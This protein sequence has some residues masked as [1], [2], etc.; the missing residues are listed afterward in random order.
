[1]RQRVLLF[2]VKLFHLLIQKASSQWLP[3]LFLRGE[4]RYYDSLGFLLMYGLYI[5][6][7]LVGRAVNQRLRAW[8]RRRRLLEEAQDESEDDEEDVGGLSI[9]VPAP[10]VS[11]PAR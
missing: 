3:H 7:V 2:Y 8:R 9:F 6:V 10:W 11:P 1:M 5:L 4:I